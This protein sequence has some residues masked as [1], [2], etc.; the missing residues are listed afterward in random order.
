MA[1]SIFPGNSLNGTCIDEMTD[2]KLLQQ[3]FD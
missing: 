2:D 1:N 3:Y